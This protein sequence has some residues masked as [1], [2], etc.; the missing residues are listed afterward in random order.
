M[1]IENLL[2]RIVMLEATVEEIKNRLD[3]QDSKPVTPA[4]APAPAPAPVT[5]SPA[6]RSTTPTAAKTR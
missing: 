3:E 4:P 2:Q 1:I 6:T 5:T